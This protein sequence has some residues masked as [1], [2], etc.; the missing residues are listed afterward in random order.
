ML[1]ARGLAPTLSAT[2]TVASAS[3]ALATVTPHA[4]AFRS[5]PP[6]GLSEKGPEKNWKCKLFSKGGWVDPKI[7]NFKKSIHSEKR[8]KMNFLITGMCFG[9][10]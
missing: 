10:F 7:Y 3:P 2:G 9:K 8:L 6:V 1:S 5:E 4:T